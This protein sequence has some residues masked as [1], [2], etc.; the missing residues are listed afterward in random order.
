MLD[1]LS[2]LIHS[3]Y[4]LPALVKTGGYLVMAAIIFAETGLFVGFFLPGDSLLVTAGIFAAKGDLDIV[5]LNFLL[6][7]AAI[8][9]D[10]V[11]YS[12]GKRAGKF[13]FERRDSLIF[14]RSHLL[15][16]KAFYDRHGGKAIFLARFVPV[17]R[18]FAPVVAGAMEMPYRRFAVFNISGA[19]AWVATMTLL[20]YYLG[21]KIPDIE[22]N[23]YFVVAIVVLLSFLPAVYEYWKERKAHTPRQEGL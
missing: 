12:I 8:V 20:G 7:A 6:M 14:R 2:Q 23:I 10:F 18:T 19:I 17:V 3:L 16:A 15:R 5:F 13:L 21:T 22:R 1:Q 4:D 11:S 9:G